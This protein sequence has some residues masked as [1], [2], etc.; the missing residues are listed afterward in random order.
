MYFNLSKKEAEEIMKTEGEVRGVV[1]KTDEKF[2]LYKGGEEKLKEV[3]KE[4]EILGFPF[5][6]AESKNMNFYPIGM[7]VLSILAIAKVFN[8]NENQ[9]KNEIGLNAPK[10]SFIIKIFAQHLFSI[11][12][13][14][15]QV[16]KL[17]SRHYSIG[18]LVP[19]KLD[20]K[21][22]EIIL[23][24]RNFKIHPILCYYLLGYF[25]KI[26]EIVVKSP[27]DIKEIECEFKNNYKHVFLIK[28]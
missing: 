5:K 27:V 16:S 3:E 2:I 9:V 20:E 24:L 15:N 4:L 19:I 23:E 10:M 28:W 18:E 26:T 12:K 7:R 8:L 21:N 17:W 25:N 13:T 1:F 14:F 22:K 6:Y 11:E